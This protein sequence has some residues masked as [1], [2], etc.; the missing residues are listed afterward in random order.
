MLHSW[1]YEASKLLLQLLLLIKLPWQLLVLLNKSVVCK[2]HIRGRHARRRWH[3]AL[4]GGCL[5]LPQLQPSPML[6]RILVCGV[7]D[8][9]IC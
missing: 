1:V 4:S 6:Q 7:N 5:L 9:L 3:G 2:S 8:T